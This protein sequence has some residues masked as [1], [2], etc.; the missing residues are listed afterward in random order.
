MLMRSL[1]TTL[2]VTAAVAPAA[3]ASDSTA[4]ADPAASQL[5]AL[6]GTLVWVSGDYG[7]QVLMRKT[8][9]GIG[10]VP[11]APQAQSYRSIDL[12]RDSSGRLV[13]TYLRC[14]SPSRCV[15]LRDDLQGHRASFRGLT[16]TRCTLSTAPAVWR[17][18]A[19]YGLQC[20]TAAKTPTFDTKRSGLYV[21]T[22]TGTPRRLPLPKSAV[23]SG[24]DLIS[25][26]DVRGTNV[27]AIAADIFEYA[28]T[29]SVT[30]SGQRSFLSAASEG[31][32][33]AHTRGLALG[34][35]GTLWSLTDAEHTGDPNQAII[36]R[37]AGSCHEWESLTNAPGPD[38]QMGF[39]AIDVVVDG[40]TTY[41]VVPGKGVVSHEFA[42][43]HPCGGP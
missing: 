1:L 33:D 9:D 39:Q 12:G 24:S 38:Q 11:A 37:L 7:A 8:A 29:E 6:D 13:L 41:L 22:G 17:T 4:A 2:A 25:S 5:T 10:R 23:K 40:A 19:V 14:S 15:A 30:G 16:L 26:V 36:H 28:F 32:S 42:P 21:K 20:R 18:R 43:V 34:P 3:M 31:E 27:A 35:G